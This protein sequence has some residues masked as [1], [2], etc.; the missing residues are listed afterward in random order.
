MPETQVA[1][2][3]VA[4]KTALG[5]L[6][7]YAGGADP[8]NPESEETPEPLNGPQIPDLFA[9]GNAPTDVAE[10]STE[11]PAEEPEEE[12]VE[13]EI[14]GAKIVV[15]D[16]KTAKTLQKAE[17]QLRDARSQMDQLSQEA[18][19]LRGVIESGQRQIPREPAP[20]DKQTP[21]AGDDADEDVQA[22]LR[23]V[24]ARL[25]KGDYD[26]G[27]I[28]K[29]IDLSA[30]ANVAPYKREL[31]ELRQE[32]YGQRLAIEQSGDAEQVRNSLK[33]HQ[34]D[35]D[36]EAVIGAFE[37]SKQAELTMLRERGLSAKDAHALL[38]DHQTRN[39]RFYA[40]IGRAYHIARGGTAETGDNDEND[41]PNPG[42]A[43]AAPVP[44][45]V[46]PGGTGPRK[47][48][49]AVSPAPAGKPAG[50]P[51]TSRE[52]FGYLS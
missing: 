50:Q 27:D 16:K 39:S 34:I 42:A 48:R 33:T 30:R 25:T 13:V 40:A 36:P 23:D 6:P 4:Q 44:R 10:E 9:V 22:D 1:E 35:L 49:T 18:E 3:E 32:M 47:A 14:N 8:A 37:V 19:S 45:R 51:M 2:G 41:K 52:L 12:P 17:K 24:L 28:A 26:E 5:D 11:A 43:P 46:P 29:A 15:P 21:D 38:D 31:A 7:D 20:R